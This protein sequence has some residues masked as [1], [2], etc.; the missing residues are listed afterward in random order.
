MNENLFLLYN[1]Y[2]IKET[3]TDSQIIFHAVNRSY[4]DF[5]RQIHFHGKNVFNQDTKNEYKSEFFLSENLPRLFESETQQDFDKTHYALCNTLIHMYDGICKWSYGIAQRLIN[6]TL[7]H[8]IVIESN[9][10]T[11]YWDIN[12]ARR[13]FHVP[14]E[15]YTLQM[16][17]AYGRDTYKHV[18]HLKCAPL[19][20]I[21]NRYHMNYYNIEKVL[22]FEKWEF[23]EYIEYQ[24]ALRKTIEESSYADPVDWW[25]QAFAEVAGIRFTHSSRSECK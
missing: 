22:P 6:Q 13:F 4:R 24:T 3:F 25:F 18:L 1:H 7:V 16:A 20:D 14:V 19:E 23:P 21:T 8:L 5:W 9:L 10:Q 17:T 12:S 11:R 15:T 2:G